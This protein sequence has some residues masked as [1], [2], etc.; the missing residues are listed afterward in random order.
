MNDD[1]YE[2]IRIKPPDRFDDTEPWQYR[3]PGLLVA[4]GL[5]LIAFLIVVAL[6]WSTGRMR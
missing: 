3:L 4:W 2:E 1:R 5:V 6:C